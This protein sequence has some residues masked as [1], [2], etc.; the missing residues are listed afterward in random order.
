M[1]CLAPG[2]LHQRG[3]PG[4][5]R[6]RV[7]R[8]K[9]AARRLVSL[10]FRQSDQSGPAWGGGADSDPECP[11]AQPDRPPTAGPGGT[12]SLKGCYTCRVLLASR[13]S[14]R[15]AF[16]GPVIS[17]PGQHQDQIDSDLGGSHTVGQVP[18][19]QAL[20][21]AGVQDTFSPP[22]SRQ[23]QGRRTRS[24]SQKDPAGRYSFDPKRKPCILWI[25]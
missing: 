16:C 5:T 14:T 7:L 17:G 19:A 23:C 13:R 20:S 3:T 21:R 15:S 4:D 22:I 9:L 12:G 2:P 18:Q 24:V 6:P 10:S 8:P 11:P 25:S 1:D